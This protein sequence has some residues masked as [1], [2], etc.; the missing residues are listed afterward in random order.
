ML[1]N[2]LYEENVRIPLLILAPGRLKKPGVIDCVGSE[3]DLLPTVMDLF[4]MTGLNHAVGTSLV[5]RVENR[6]AYF[7]NPFAMQYLGMRQGSRKLIFNVRAGKS[8]LYD[9]VADP[10]EEHDVADT[11]P[12]QVREWQQEVKAIHQYL[13]QLYLTERFVGHPH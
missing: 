5:R 3:I 4:G 12:E 13:L 1:V 11:S 7:N 8:S 9:I 10:R 6:K 2:Y